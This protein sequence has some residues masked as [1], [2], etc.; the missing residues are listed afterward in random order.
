MPA[1]R[2]SSGAP[3]PPSPGGGGNFDPRTM[4]LSCQVKIAL[5]ARPEP[6]EIDRE[7]TAVLLV[8]M[9]NAFASTG[10]MLDLA[11][12]DVKPAPPAGANAP[13]GRPPA[14]APTPPAIYPSTR[15]PPPPPTP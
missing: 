10:G 5:P 12:I 9:Q 6:I 7:Q 1:P 11:G 14:P 3:T 4:R 15:Y 8:D 13:P 2:R